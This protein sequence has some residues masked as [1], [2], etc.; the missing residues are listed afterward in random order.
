MA[1]V[2]EARAGTAHMVGGTEEEA[3]V[4]VQEVIGCQISALVC[5][6]KHGVGEETGDQVRLPLQHFFCAA[7]YAKKTL[8]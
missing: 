7:G 8:A 4:E 1:T 5:K 2:A 3:M 6:S